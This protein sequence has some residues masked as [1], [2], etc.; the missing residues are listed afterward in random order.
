MWEYSSLKKYAMSEIL[1]VKM[2]KRFKKWCELRQRKPNNM[3]MLKKKRGFIRA[4]N[5]LSCFSL[6]N[7]IRLSQHGALDAMEM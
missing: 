1:N 7:R 6:L 4:L 2:G 3:M 5:N